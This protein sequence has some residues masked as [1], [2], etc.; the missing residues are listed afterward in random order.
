MED[1]KKQVLSLGLIAS[2][3]RNQL[4]SAVY[5]LDTTQED[6]EKAKYMALDYIDHAEKNL[7]EL[8]E[9]AGNI[10]TKL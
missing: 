10:A 6:A 7:N 1:L 5:L 3:I 4:E 8:A 2:G 9:K